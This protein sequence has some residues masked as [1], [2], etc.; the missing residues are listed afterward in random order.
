M[1]LSE[2][3]NKPLF[4]P[5]LFFILHHHLD[6]ALSVFSHPPPPP[7]FASPP[8]RPPMNISDRRR[9]DIA[10]ANWNHKKEKKTMYEY[11]GPGLL[12]S[13]TWTRLFNKACVFL[14]KFARSLW[15]DSVFFFFFSFSFSLAFSFSTFFSFSWLLSLCCIVMFCFWGAKPIIILSE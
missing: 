6:L 4:L 1:I 8:P 3:G 12:V 15:S 13:L 10:S 5:L 7:D 14:A 11:E 2:F 9:S